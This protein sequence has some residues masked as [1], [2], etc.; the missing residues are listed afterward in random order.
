LH[1]RIETASRTSAT[2]HHAVCHAGAR[3]LLLLAVFIPAAV[4]VPAAAVAQPVLDRSPN[5]AGTWVTSPRNLFF[6]ISHR[7]QVVGGDVDVTDIFDGAKIVNYPTFLL[8]YGL[9]EDVNIGFRYSSNSALAGGPN[10][11]QPYATWGAVRSTGGAG[12]SLALTGAWNGA[13]QSVDVELSS[14]IRFGRIGLLGAVRGFS[15]AFENAADDGEA[16]LALAGGAVVSITRYLALAG[17]VAGRVA[18]PSGDLAWSAGLQVGIPYTPHT[19]SLLA[20]NVSSG[21]LQGTSTGVPGVVYWGFEFTIPFS[22]FARWGDIFDPDEGS[23]TTG[24]VPPPQ[25]PLL[26]PPAAAT[27]RRVTELRIS[28]LRYER[29]ELRVPLGTTVRWINRDPVAHTVTAD[30]GAWTSPLIG[31][32]DVFEHTFSTSGEFLYHCTPHPFM[33]ARVTVVEGRDTPAPQ[34]PDGR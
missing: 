24:A 6:E 9:L 13:A 27:E 11:W 21:T 25:T 14:Q 1:L 22:G 18:G 10:E 31:P 33:Q 17:D 29:T 8:A 20:T 12:P 3:A 7:F 19:F 2:P 16:A 23:S 28:G 26:A 5:M 30:D 34:T 4:V 32:G 15:Q